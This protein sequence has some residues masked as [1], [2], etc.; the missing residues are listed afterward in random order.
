MAAINEVQRT[1][2]TSNDDGSDDG[3]WK[4]W[5]LEDDI[6]TNKEMI[7]KLTARVAVLEA[8][9]MLQKAQKGF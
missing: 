5:E 6:A 7:A 1:D 8:E 9:M 4:D 2:L 3:G